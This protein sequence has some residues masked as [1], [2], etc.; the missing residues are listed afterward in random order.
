MPGE[1]PRGGDPP[2]GPF[3]LEVPPA[4]PNGHDKR[5]PPSRLRR[6]VGGLPGGVLV[7][8]LLAVSIVPR[9]SLLN[10]AFFNPWQRPVIASGIGGIVTGAVRR[11]NVWT[12]ALAGGV[13]AMLALWIVYTGTRLQN[14]VLWVERSAARVITAD[15]T[16]LA[17]YALPAGAAGA[18]A[19][20]WARATISAFRARRQEPLT[21]LGDM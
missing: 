6:A 12:A 19:G 15:L 7:A 17:A 20:R 13:A 4:S 9:L 8:G 16:R 18:L 3:R 21:E 14:P 2:Y 10:L 1:P 11:S 5:T